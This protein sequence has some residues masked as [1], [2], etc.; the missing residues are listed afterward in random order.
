MDKLQYPIG[1]FRPLPE[2][3]ARE[4]EH[5]ITEIDE[6]PKRL[7]AAILGLGDEQL[8]T[9]YRP[10]GWTVRQVVHHLPDS[11]L[12]AYCRVKLALTEENPT[13][14]PY[15]EALWAELPEARAAGTEISV[16][17]LEALHARWVLMLQSL[18]ED[19]WRRPLVHPESGP[20]TVERVVALYA[21]H[22]RHHVGH[23]NALRQRE[24]WL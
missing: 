18:K 14:R 24:R 13:I 1:R 22:G 9:P 19:E 23:I 16:G 8:D 6:A 20:Q 5:A 21:W 12:N 10:G 7:R 4:R 2:Y 11:H 15:D 3:S 17:L